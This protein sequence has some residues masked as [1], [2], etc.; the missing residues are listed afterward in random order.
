MLLVCP[1]AGKPQ[2]EVMWFKNG[3]SLAG[4]PGFFVLMN[5]SLQQTQTEL[6]DEGLYTCEGKNRLGF[7]RSPNISLTVAS[8]S[9]SNYPF[10]EYSGDPL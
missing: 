8:K 1:V 2:V 5:G 10:T 3:V 4:I 7:I 9:A 6:S